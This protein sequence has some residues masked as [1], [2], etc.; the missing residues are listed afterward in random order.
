MSVHAIGEE[1]CVVDFC[2]VLDVELGSELI[3][4]TDIPTAGLIVNANDR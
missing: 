1:T 3:T 4:G 2:V